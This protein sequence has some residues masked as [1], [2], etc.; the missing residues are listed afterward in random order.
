MERREKG[1]SARS[2]DMGGILGSLEIKTEGLSDEVV[3]VGL[4]AG[5][6]AGWYCWYYWF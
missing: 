1:E 6:G 5:T 3:E 2:T 4:E